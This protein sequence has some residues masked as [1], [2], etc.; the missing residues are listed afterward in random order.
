MAKECTIWWVWLCSITL[1]HCSVIVHSFQK[2]VSEFATFHQLPTFKTLIGFALRVSRTIRVF[3]QIWDIFLWSLQSMGELASIMR[4]GRHFLITNA[5]SFHWLQAPQKMSQIWMNTLIVLD[6]RSANPM[7]V[8]KCTEL[9][10]CGKIWLKKNEKECM[11][12]EQWKRVMP[13]NQTHKIVHSSAMYYQHFIIIHECSK[14]LLKM[15]N[16]NKFL[17]LHLY[18]FHF[19]AIFFSDLSKLYFFYS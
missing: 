11:I 18:K 19:Y 7:R 1:F 6:T 14:K 5:N 9:V 16:S 8:L 2:I 13:H 10:K 17:F 12:T 4:K 15:K 3:I